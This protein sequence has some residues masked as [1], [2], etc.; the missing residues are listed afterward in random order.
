MSIDL[1]AFKALSFDIYATLIDWELDIYQN[2]LPL[3]A[4][5]PASHPQH[6]APA[7][8]QRVFLLSSFVALELEIQAASPKMRYSDV[9]TNIY[10]RLAADL[11]VPSAAEEE[12][13][14]GA[15]VGSWPP[16][17]DTVAA[18]QVLSKYYKL[19][20]LSNVDG[21]SFSRTLAGPLNGVN[22]DAIYTAEE[23]GS[24]KPNLANFEYLISHIKADLG[25]EKSEILHVAQSLTHDHVPAKSIG[26][27]PGVWI[28]R[29][30]AGTET[31][32]GGKAEELEA[33]G[34]IFLGATFTT[35]GEFAEE[36]ERQWAGKKLEK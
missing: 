4:R 18:M 19:V 6:N 3:L 35:L 2:L 22:F 13:A 15:S 1:T 21:D 16:F 17:P 27:A 24:Y 28:E 7:A 33:E 10:A 31:V 32:M 14:F 5:V 23:I 11:G 25:A 8:A 30:G 12:R 9:L 34:K 26:L 29:G 20:V 36:V